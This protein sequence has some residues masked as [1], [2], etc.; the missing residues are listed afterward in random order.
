MRNGFSCCDVDQQ[1]EEIWGGGNDA[2]AASGEDGTA[3]NFM[4]ETAASPGFLDF[5]LKRFLYL[6][7]AF[8]ISAAMA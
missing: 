4:N 2:N 3:C 7:T 8:W 6:N 5:L 1:R